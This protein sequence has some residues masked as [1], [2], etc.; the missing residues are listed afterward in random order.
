MGSLVISASVP[1]FEQAIHFSKPFIFT[2]T[3][4]FR[5]LTRL[6]KNF[7]SQAPRRKDTPLSTVNHVERNKTRQIGPAAP[8]G[9]GKMPAI[10]LRSLMPLHSPYT[11]VP[12]KNLAGSAAFDV[13]LND[14][15]PGK[16]PSWQTGVKSLEKR[17]AAEEKKLGR[18][19]TCD[20]WEPRVRRLSRQLEARFRDRVRVFSSYKFTDFPP[21]ATLTTMTTNDRSTVDSL[22]DVHI[23]GVV[24]DIDQVLPK[25]WEV[26][27]RR[28]SQNCTGFERELIEEAQDL[29]WKTNRKN[30]VQDLTMLLMYVEDPE[31]QSFRPLDILAAPEELK[32]F[33]FDKYPEQTHAAF[34]AHAHYLSS[35]RIIQTIDT[36]KDLLDTSTGFFRDPVM[37]EQRRAALLETNAILKKALPLVQERER[38]QHRIADMHHSQVVDAQL[39]EE[40]VKNIGLVDDKLAQLFPTLEDRKKLGTLGLSSAMEGFVSKI[41]SNTRSEAKEIGTAWKPGR[42]TTLGDKNE[43]MK[44]KASLINAEEARLDAEAQAQGIARPKPKKAPFDLRFREKLLDQVNGM[45]SHVLETNKIGLVTFVDPEH[46]HKVI[47]P[48]REQVTEHTSQCTSFTSGSPMPKVLLS[49]GS[50]EQVFEVDLGRQKVM[51][52]KMMIAFAWTMANEFHFLP[53]MS[54]SSKQLHV[55]EQGEPKMDSIARDPVTGKPWH[56]RKDAAWTH[57]RGHSQEILNEVARLIARAGVNPDQESFTRREEAIIRMVFAEETVLIGNAE[58]MGRVRDIRKEG[59]GSRIPPENE[60]TFET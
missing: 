47:K 49:W 40:N 12:E 30:I 45:V 9:Q 56:W 29:D 28:V 23:D 18:A 4:M 35:A 21:A 25:A 13:Q 24:V 36:N 48:Y 1:S 34:P 53:G 2:G 11:S 54:E 60:K 50:G 6:S 19:L 31:N 32:V 42:I 8:T 3:I 17:F 43:S 20:E 5:H 7:S 52:N 58:V 55:M 44:R 37:C 14:R 10:S 33:R 41:E 22:H 27:L 39:L 15:H 51:T 38:L 46:Q 16:P 26:A 57:N 59:M